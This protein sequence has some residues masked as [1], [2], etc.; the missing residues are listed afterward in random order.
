M[1]ERQ[2]SWIRWRY[3]VCPNSGK[4]LR[5]WKDVY[6]S[7]P[8][9]STPAMNSQMKGMNTAQISRMYGDKRTSNEPCNWQPRAD[10]MS[11]SSALQERVKLCWQNDFL[12]FYLRLP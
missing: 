10:I 12:Q 11:Y 5:C 9:R 7:N 6:N 1:R 2:P 4:C 8:W 3:M